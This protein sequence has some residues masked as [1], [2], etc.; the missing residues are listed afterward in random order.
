MVLGADD[1]LGRRCCR[2][3]G[4]CSRRAARRCCR[5]PCASVSDRAERLLRGGVPKTAVT[6]PSGSPR[7]SAETRRSVVRA[8]RVVADRARRLGQ[9]RGGGQALDMAITPGAG[10]SPDGAAARAGAPAAARRPSRARARGARAR[11]MPPGPSDAAEALWLRAR[12][13]E[14]ADRMPEAVTAYKAAGVALSACARWPA[15]RCGSS[16]WYAYLKGDLTRRR[17]SHGRSWSRARAIAPTGSARSTGGRARSSGAGSR[18]A[19]MP[20]CTGAGAQPRRRAATTACWPPVEVG[21]LDR[22]ADP[23]H[24]HAARRSVRG[25]GRAIPGVRCGSSCCGRLGLIEAALEEL[26]GAVERAIG[27]PRADSAACPT[28][29]R[30]TTRYHHRL[31]IHRRHLANLAASGDPGCRA[32]SGRP[33]I[34]FAWR[35]RRHG[36]RRSGPGSSRIWWPAVVREEYLV[37]SAV[38]CPRAGARGLMQLMPATARPMAEHRGLAAR[39]ASCSTTPARISRW[40][41][42]SWAA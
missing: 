7:E 20:R 34:P 12:A 10:G 30:A 42:R 11:G 25:A 3:A 4:P 21:G 41:P 24:D 28:P 32:H 40:A 8:L 15:A 31:R 1:R 17:S 22:R 2:S 13:L 37:L 19:A 14:D 6:K 9:L 26:D 18:A 33:S 35:E 39:A 23:G 5:S 29:T 16:G 27:V 36:G 38:P